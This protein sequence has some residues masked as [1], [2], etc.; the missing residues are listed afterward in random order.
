ML[1]ILLTTLAAQAAAQEPVAFVGATLHPVSGPVIADGV[2][3]IDR[4][5][6]LDVGPAARVGV[7]TRA[8]RVDATGK[9]IVPGLIDLHSHIGGGDLHEGLDV[10][11]PGV[12]AIDAIDPTHPSIQRAQAGGIT[13]ANVMPG[14]GKLLGGQTAHLSLRD[15]A[16]IDEML[17]CNGAS[18]NVHPTAPR[19]RAEICG[20]VKMAA[21]TNPQGDGK[22]PRTR[23]GAAYLQRAA[24]QKGEE[25]RAV[26]DRH[27]SKAATQRTRRSDRPVDPPP[28]EL[29]A[30]A[31]VEVLRG[32]RIVHLHAHRADDIVT[33]LRLA[34]EF[35]LRLVVHHGSEGFK[36]ADLLAAADVP[37]AINVLDTPGGK[38]ETLERRLDNPA[39]LIEAGVRIALIT[40]D[41]VQDSRL[42]LRTAG[43]AVRGGL[44]PAAALEALTLTP[45]R[46]LGL[47]HA[48]GSLDIGKEADLVVLS[49]PP[50]S[51]W[52][53]VE[54]TWVDGALVFD[55]AD[56]AQ[57]SYATGGDAV[58]AGSR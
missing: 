29:E 21:G 48:T 2:V 51:A 31:L 41:P 9:H 53:L 19:R 39:M 47:E 8:R 45:A 46:I 20:G 16:V 23:M 32:D 30:D 24:L 11:L 56:R 58:L 6:I 54:Q 36:V 37:V 33:G 28:E 49:G 13:T 34:E 18:A 38:E 35:G 10:L 4:G 27:A 22:D 55:R 44:S 52:T 57:R 43:L 42:F 5:R 17:L 26:L 3:V 40:D 25:R 50:T 12:S 7:P 1:V 15:T 14:S